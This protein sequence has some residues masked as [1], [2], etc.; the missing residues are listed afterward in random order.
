MKL[1][2]FM[3]DYFLFYRIFNKFTNPNY[4]IIEAKWCQHVPFG[5]VFAI[6]STYFISS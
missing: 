5:Y 6:Q 2:V 3:K 1:F 4:E